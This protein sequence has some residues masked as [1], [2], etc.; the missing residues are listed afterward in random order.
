MDPIDT[1]EER[2][3]QLPERAQQGIQKAGCGDLGVLV[4]AVADIN[5][6]VQSETKE[7][8][9]DAQDQ[10]ENSTTDNKQDAEDQD[11]NS[12]T[13]N[14]DESREIQGTFTGSKTKKW[15]VQWDDDGNRTTKNQGN[16]CCDVLESLILSSNGTTTACT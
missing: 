13:D 2:D 11:E 10:D 4:L 8:K 1:E 16:N 14:S 5:N 7:G 12:T 3:H 9:P 6:Y 15:N